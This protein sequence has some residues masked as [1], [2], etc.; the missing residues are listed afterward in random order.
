MKT[1]TRKRPSSNESSEERFPST[2]SMSTKSGARDPIWSARA[3]AST[4]L[5]LEPVR[6]LRDDPVGQDIGDG[7]DLGEDLVERV[8]VAGP[9]LLQP[10]HDLPLGQGEVQPQEVDHVPLRP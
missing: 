5:L 6:E 2:P 1:R 10:G 7:Q 8:D 3:V 4:A 9:I